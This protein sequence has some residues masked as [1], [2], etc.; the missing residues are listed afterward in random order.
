MEATGLH[1][2]HVHLA[3]R[4]E[5]HPDSWATQLRWY[6]LAAV[7]GFAVPLVGSSILGLQHDLYL[8]VYFAAVGA[9]LWAYAAATRLDVRAVALRNWKLGVVLGIVVGALLVRN[10]LSEQATP[11]PSGAYYWFELVW[12]GGV[13]GAVDALLLTVLPCLVVHRSLGG[14]LPSWRLRLEYVGAALALVVTLTAI[15]HLGY[16]QYRQD[17]VRAPETGNV[18]ISLPM[19]LSANPIGSVADHMAM[20]ISAVR[21]EYETEVRLPPPTKAR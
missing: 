12:R 7:V 20:H 16:S 21:H 18:I 13:Y 8:A 19:L 15:Y 9:L 14:R 17:G 11:H 3:P 4:R 2:P 5:A 10:V 6:A 1:L